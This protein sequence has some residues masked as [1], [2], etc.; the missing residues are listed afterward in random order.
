[1][2]LTVNR[3]A[4]GHSA[5]RC[6]SPSRHLV[7]PTVTNTRVNESGTWSF[8]V[9]NPG[10]MEQT[11]WSTLNGC[12][13]EDEDVIE[14]VHKVTDDAW[15]R[16]TTVGERFTDRQRNSRSPARPP[17]FQHASYFSLITKL[18]IG[19]QWRIEPGV[20]AVQ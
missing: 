10:T 9:A 16:T 13:M 5:F 20:H 12:Q 15:S 4:D 6:R 17:R 14:A 7:N 18:N 11:T 8:Q 19:L 1:M 3:Y 2:S